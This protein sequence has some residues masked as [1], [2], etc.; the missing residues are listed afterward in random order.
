MAGWGSNTFGYLK[1][2]EFGNA[3]VNVTNPNDTYWG[4]DA[5]GNFYWGGGGNLDASIGEPTVTAEVNSGFGGRTWNFGSWGDLKNVNLI[6]TSFSLDINQGQAE[7]FVRKGWGATSYGN[8]EWGDLSDTTALPTGIEFTATLGD[9]TTAGEINEGWGRLTWGQNIWNGFGQVI[10][11]GQEL[12]SNTGSV[13]IDN[14]INSGWGGSVWG[15]TGWGAFGTAYISDGIQMSA[16]LGAVT[17][18]NE[19]N[20]GWGSDTWG[21][22]TW[23]ISGLVVDLTGIG[24]TAT[25]DDLTINAD[26]QTDVL[27]GEEMTA[28]EGDAEGFASFVADVTGQPMTA[29]LQ[30]QEAVVDVFNPSIGGNEFS[31]N[32]DAQLSTAQKE[33]GTAS[34]LLDG[35]GDYVNASGTVDG[36]DGGAFT[37]EF[38]WYASDATTQT[39]I[40][41]D[42]RNAS[43]DGYSIGI[44]NG[45]LILYEDGAQL[46][47][48][49]GLFSNNTWM[50]LAF[51]RDASNNGALWSRGTRRNAIG[52]GLVNNNNSNRTFIG[53]DLNGANAVSAYIDEY[54]QSNIARYNPVTEATITVPTSEFSTDANTVNLLHFDGTNGSTIILNDVSA[55]MAMTMNEGTADLDANTIV[56]VSATSAASW[57]NSA[58]GY[59][60]YGNQQVDTLVMGMQEGDVDPAPDANIIGIEMT[61]TLD[62]V[63]TQGD[64]NTGTIT[65]IAWGEQTWGQ[66][67]WGNGQ[68]FDATGYA[69]AATI[70]LGTA[71]L[72]AN[73]IA[74]VSGQEMTI[75]EN[76][77][78]E[79]TG[80]AN[81]LLSGNA[82][83]MAE[84][85]LKTLI[86]NEVNTGTAPVVPPGW[87]EVDTAA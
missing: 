8:G 86:W 2:G 37:I 14:E 51:A 48:S 4:R 84:G 32:G 5:Y 54:R 10:P 78:D 57:G 20:I 17:V 42:G 26:G 33:F 83:T 59:G 1:W 50:H 28:A 3:Y 44:D 69:Q 62:D 82:L 22:E 75:Q 23:G 9:E 81:V 34:L 60:V 11:T 72:D 45:N 87:Q 13:T 58:W 41:W 31:V 55:S 18:D 65:D 64:A 73:T 80:N 29:T 25:L 40:L 27:T 46:S 12:N 79:V 35:T 49:S 56:E 21:Y 70:N 85:S 66:S 43:G 19:I 61:A 30:Y 38:W 63:V 74:E 16:N 47:S 53:A 6:P 39:G 77:V 36:L 76:D 24:L 52:G 15:F 67:T 7:S 71:V 68:Y